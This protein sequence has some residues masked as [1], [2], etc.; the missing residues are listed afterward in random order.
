MTQ[1]PKNNSDFRQNLIIS[2]TGH[3]VTPLIRPHKKKIIY[4]FLSVLSC[5]LWAGCFVFWLL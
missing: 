2:F 5:V 4:N 1:N 3:R